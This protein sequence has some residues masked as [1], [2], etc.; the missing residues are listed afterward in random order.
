MCAATAIVSIPLPS[1]LASFTLRWTLAV[2]L[3]LL[4][5]SVVVSGI[6]WWR[7]SHYAASMIERSVVDEC[8][9]LKSLPLSSL[10]RTIATRTDQDLHRKRYLALFDLDGTVV[11]GNL[12]RIPAGLPVDG[13]AHQFPVDRNKPVAALD[14]GIVSACHDGAGR[15]LLVGRDLDELDDLG[16]L[17]IHA[18]GLAAIP[19]TF[20]AIVGGALLAAQ[21]QRRLGQAERITRQVMAG[22]LSER[23]PHSASRDTFGRLASNVNL[24]L[25]RIEMLVAEVRGVGDDIAHQLKTPLT[26]LRAGLERAILHSTGRDDLLVASEQAIREID[27]ALEIIAALLRIREIEVS[28]RTS[29]FRPLSIARVVRDAVE[30]Y[31]AKA[32]ESQVALRFE[33]DIDPVISGD[34]DLLMEAIANLVDNAIKFSPDGGTVTVSLRQDGARFALLRVADQGPGVPPAERSEVFHRFY[35]MARDNRGPGVGLGL[36]LVAAI[37]T[38]HG[39]ILD[40]DDA[41]P[42][43]IVVARLPLCFTDRRLD[44]VRV[45]VH[46]GVPPGR[47]HLQ[48]G[49]P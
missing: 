7:T 3:V 32:E 24:M 23:I 48:A 47:P 46:P 15:T 18:I 26:R 36:S 8:S 29:H 27:E 12:A 45:D 4:F 42:G 34:A 20:I 25:D 28:A 21:S 31:A 38:L 5:Q 43:C 44:E 39:I 40:F 9:D 22:N 2:C 14:T 41:A 1:V 33:T 13:A 35:R 6:F 16:R 30:L 37:A 49:R 11:A 19:A 17:V 10:L